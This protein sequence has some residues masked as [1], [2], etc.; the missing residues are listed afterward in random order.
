MAYFRMLHEHERW[1]EIEELVLIPCSLCSSHH[2]PKVPT[3]AVQCQ[4]LG[5]SRALQASH[6]AFSASFDPFL[7]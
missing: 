1:E 3:L 6:F 4:R 7:R 2:G 5:C